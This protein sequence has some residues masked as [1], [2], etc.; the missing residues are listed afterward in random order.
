MASS[1][2]KM[3]DQAKVDDNNSSSSSNK[4]SA[5]LPKETTSTPTTTTSW[6]DSFVKTAKEKSA[7]ALE[8]MRTDLAEFKTTMST[9]TSRLVHTLADVPSSTAAA[10]AA[11]TAPSSSSLFTSLTSALGLTNLNLL[12]DDGVEVLKAG[13]WQ[14]KEE[15]EEK[16]RRLT[17]AAATTTAAN[18]HERFRIELKQMQACASTFAVDGAGPEFELWASKFNSDDFKSR[19]SDLLIENSETRLLYSQ[20]VLNFFFTN[21]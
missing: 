19:I 5:A 1:S 21:C 13:K 7:S 20:L 8:I 14:K 9:D 2:S 15:E 11:A 6:W 3:D 18:I 10:A 16:D 4:S 12:G 17:A